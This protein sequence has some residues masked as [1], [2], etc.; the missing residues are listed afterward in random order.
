MVGI[1]VKP[2]DAEAE[3]GALAQVYGAILA[4][5]PDERDIIILG[6]LNADG[7]YF[8]EGGAS[9]LKIS[10]FTWAISNDMDTM[11]KTDSGLC[12]NP[13]VAMSYLS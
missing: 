7:S 10:T 11:T 9:S 5:D 2:D 1:H 13:Q 6:D 4:R 3:I 8:D 12:K